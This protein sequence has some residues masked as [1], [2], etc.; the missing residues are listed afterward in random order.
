MADLQ[1]TCTLKASAFL[2]ATETYITHIGGVWGTITEEQAIRDI[3]THTHTY[4]TLVGGRRANIHPHQGRH[5][6]FLKTDADGYVPNNLL[7]LP[8]C[9]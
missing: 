7:S 9:R 2:H 3:D 4:Y 6:R 1:V 5:R 8:N